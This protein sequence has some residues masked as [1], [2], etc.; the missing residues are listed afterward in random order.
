M[1]E[2]PNDLSKI[3][4]FSSIPA[5]IK[6]VFNF[7]YNKE[8][9]LI[10]RVLS[11]YHSKINS[12]LRNALQTRMQLIPPP[13]FPSIKESEQEIRN[14]LPEFKAPDQVPLSLMNPKFFVILLDYIEEFKNVVENDESMLKPL[15]KMVE[16][17]Y[18]QTG[19]GR[20]LLKKGLIKLDLK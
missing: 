15:E 16:L 3:Y 10:E 14:A 17:F 8:I 5:F 6:R 2:T 20:Y 1:A 7:E 4:Y 13:N 18:T 11:F 19:N 12:E 9:L